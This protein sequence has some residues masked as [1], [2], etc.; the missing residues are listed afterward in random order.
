MFMYLYGS[1]KYCEKI[2]IINIVIEVNNIDIKTII[3]V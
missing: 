3:D 2:Y 1:I